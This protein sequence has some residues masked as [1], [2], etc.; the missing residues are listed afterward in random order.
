LCDAIDEFISAR[1]NL[2]QVIILQSILSNNKI[3]N[4]DVILTFGKSSIVVKLLIAAREAGLNFSVI[5]VDSRPKLEGTKLLI[6]GKDAL[7][8]YSRAGIKCTYV[9]THAL[10]FVINKATKVFVGAST[11]LS[12]GDMMSRVGTSVLC[13]A[14]YDAKV[15]VV[16]LCESYKFAE[17]VRLDSFVWNELGI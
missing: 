10:P 7:E 1:I 16:A 4:L 15:P 17:Y 5:V 9:L 11:F 13:M 6:L 3:K 8:L 12:N 2:S 14:A